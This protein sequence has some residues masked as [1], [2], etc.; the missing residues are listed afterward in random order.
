MVQIEEKNAVDA[1]A[2]ARLF[3][4][5]VG[6]FGPTRKGGTLNPLRSVAISSLGATQI[7]RLRLAGTDFLSRAVQSS[8]ESRP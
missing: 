1:G 3:D 8:I 2:S 6:H 7:G 4:A 5:E